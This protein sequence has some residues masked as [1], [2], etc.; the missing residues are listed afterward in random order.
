MRRVWESLK[1]CTQA[2]G[3]LNVQLC[4]HEVQEGAN[5]AHVLP[6]V[7]SLAIFIHI[8]RRCHAYRYRHGLEL[9]HADFFSSGPL[10]TWLDV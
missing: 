7:S 6:L 1:A 4:R 3:E 8:Q 9:S 5:Q 2:H 10:C